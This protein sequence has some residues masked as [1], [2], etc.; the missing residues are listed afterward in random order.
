MLVFRTNAKDIGAL[1]VGFIAKGSED[2]VFLVEEV[3][4]SVKFGDLALVH[5]EDTV[6][7]SCRIWSADASTVIP[8]RKRT[9]GV[10]TMGNAK[11]SRSVEL[12]LDGSLQLGVGLD[13]DTAGGFIKDDHPAVLHQGTGEGQKLLFTSTEVGA[14]ITD[15][16][17]QTELGF[18]RW[19]SL[20]ILG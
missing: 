12:G 6:I 20:A 16:G 8:I 7:V 17:V 3:E 2:R 19:V 15:D 9:N 1:K 18:R 10:Q 5:N 14:F 4:D 13:I 11:E